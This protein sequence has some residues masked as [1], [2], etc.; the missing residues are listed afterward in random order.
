MALIAL[1]AL[2]APRV[3]RAEVTTPAGSNGWDDTYVPEEGPRKVAPVSEKPRSPDGTGETHTVT[4][5]NQAKAT[6]AIY[7][8]TGDLD[9]ARPITECSDLVCKVALPDGRYRLLL[10][11]T[12][13][14]R[15]S[16]VAALP[17]YADRNLELYPPQPRRARRGLI[18]GIT[19]AGVAKVGG[20]LLSVALWTA[21]SGGAGYG[22]RNTAIVGGSMFGAGLVTLV[23][24]F[25]CFAHFRRPRLVPAPGDQRTD[26][27]ARR[28][29]VELGLVGGAG[30]PGFSVAF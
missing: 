3:A 7:P 6:V 28:E 19:G 13:T 24:G 12:A 23:P 14:E 8:G 25:I 4:I 18:V 10:Q 1:L 17:V 15:R 11:P 27:H 9:P 29:G 5:R 20:T 22:T 2:V 16:P 26:W 21:M 30:V